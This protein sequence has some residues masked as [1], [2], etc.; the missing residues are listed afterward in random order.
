MTA[1]KNVVIIEL[2]L[3]NCY[4]VGGGELTFGVDKNFVGVGGGGGDSSR[5]VG[6]SKFSAG[7][8][9]AIPPVGKTLLIGRFPVMRLNHVRIF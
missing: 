5:W 7:R 2:S 8:R 3:E 4:L 6:M 9:G 1:T